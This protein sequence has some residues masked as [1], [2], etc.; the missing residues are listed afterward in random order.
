MRHKEAAKSV[1]LTVLVLMS[2]I[3]TYM[4]WNFSPDLADLESQDN[5]KDT[6]NTIGKANSESIENAI[7]P[8][9]VVYANDE[10]LKGALETRALNREVTKVLKNQEVKSYNEIYYDHNLFIPELSSKFVVLDFSYDMPLS[11]YIGQ[12]L[13]MDSKLTGKFRF[14]RLIL[15]ADQK[16]NVVFYAIGS[17]RH[18]VMKLDTTIPSKNIKHLVKAISPKLAPYSGIITNKDTI[19]SAT[20]IFA[21]EQPKGLK[22][23]RTIFNH[24]SVETM[25]SILFNDSVVVRS[26]KSGTTTYNNNTGVANYN[27]KNELY[28]YTNLSEDESKSKN[29]TETIPSTFDYINSHGGFTDDFRLFE[30]NPKS[31]EL[32]YQMFLNGLPVFNKDDLSTIQVAWGE[33]GIFSYAR[34]LL[35]TNIT[36]DSDETNSDLPSAEKV[37][38]SLAN[39]PN[40]DFKKVTNMTIGYTMKDKDEHDIEVQRNS[41]YIPQWYVQYDGK[42]YAYSNG[43]LK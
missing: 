21:P 24:I 20:H 15:D 23:Y 22:T 35:K 27:T 12:V 42:W 6:Q 34:A 14:N 19:D 36:I 16:S 39:N 30:T 3:L 41:E 9:Q 25:N 29:M 33:K 8:F 11:T 31:G 26:S 37:R 40:I 18:H 7:A 43:G 4:M 28:R 32:T 38:S 17:D 10:N 5:K 2:I 1:I 13:N